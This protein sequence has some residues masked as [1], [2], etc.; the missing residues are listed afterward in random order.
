MNPQFPGNSS[1][2]EQSQ[3]ST[4]LSG[5][6]SAPAARPFMSGSNDGQLQPGDVIG[7]YEVISLLGVGGMGYVYKVSHKI[8]QKTFALKTLSL[9]KVNETTWRRLQLEAQAIAR[10]NHPNIIGISNLGMHDGVL[11]FY[12]MDVLVGENLDEVLKR[13]GALTVSDSLA[14]FKEVCAGLGY[15]HRKGIIH[16]DIKPG[17]IFLLNRKDAAGA[18]IKIV[19]FGIAKLSGADPDNQ[20]L[21]TAGEV[22]G[23]PYY[24]SPEHCDGKRIDAR[25][26]IYSVG[27]TFFEIL[28]GMPPFRGANPVQTMLMHQGQ[29][30]PKMNQVAPHANIPQPLEEIVAKMLAKAPMDRYQ[31]LDQVLEALLDFE[32]D[33][34]APGYISP[35]RGA[36]AGKL[37]MQDN[38]DDEDSGDSDRLTG[39]IIKIA[40]ASGVVLSLGA[41][42]IWFGLE[43]SRSHVPVAPQAD[44]INSTLPGV[45]L[46]PT[47]SDDRATNIGTDQTLHAMP[48][49]APAKPY[50][51]GQVNDGAITC[52]QYDFRTTRPFAVLDFE[53]YN[54]RRVEAAGVQLVPTDAKVVLRCKP[55]LIAEP[56]L[57][58]GFAV[59]DL[60]CVDFEGLSH[61]S[62]ET[63]AHVA[64]LAG[65]N[66]VIIKGGEV[67]DDCIKYLEYLPDL[68]ELALAQTK[69]SGRALSRLSR[70]R[71]LKHLD[72]SGGSDIPL[73]LKTL[74]NS[75]TMTELTLENVP[76]SKDDL[77]LIASLQSLKALRISG[78]GVTNSMMAELAHMPRLKEIEV[79]ECALDVNSLKYFKQMPALKD[80]FI[81][82]EKFHAAD[83]VAFSSGLGQRVFVHN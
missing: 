56:A 11:P 83:S 38:N 44:L 50:V 25:S 33:M 26:D 81:S 19:D 69:V 23:S 47:V 21:T 73:L 40:V 35:R 71:K 51:I 42:A 55:N 70:L 77:K 3:E 39:L 9:D 67:D 62:N 49:I 30:A 79:R 16:R 72:Y 59:D 74:E 8:L 60:F 76:L 14:I 54:N 20:N 15:A 32:E 41:G 82:G 27:C 66:G 64:R 2:D 6:S 75:K 80:I 63:L 12:V 13:D 58:D 1:D 37:K 34:K 17:N 68:R 46:R 53:N 43:Q 22:F 65:L 78:S 10:M 31:N 28:T 18:T 52:K 29:K 57:L 36:S 61:V 7:E 24:M 48:T 4:R 5:N 45:T